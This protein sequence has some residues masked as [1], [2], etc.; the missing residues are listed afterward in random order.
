LFFVSALSFAA[1]IRP[2]MIYDTNVIMDNSWNE[3]IHNGIVRFEQKMK[4][5][6]EEVNIVD[7]PSFTE[8]VSKYVEEGYGP[9]MLNNVDSGKDVILKEILYAYPQTRFIVFNGIFNIPNAFYFMFS[10]QESSFLAG[11]LA[12]KKTK[13]NRLGFVGGM[14]IATIR[15]FLCGYISGARYY[16][17]DIKVDWDFIGKDFLAWDRPEDAYQLALKQI[18]KGADIIFTPSG[19]SS[20]GALRATHERGVLGIGVDSNQNHLFPG[21]VLTSALVKVDNAV[22]RALLAAQRNIWGDQIKTMGLQ[23]NG[24]GLAYDK[25]NAPLISE[26][27]RNEVEA[28]K[29]KII[30][31]EIKINNYVHDKQCNINGEVLF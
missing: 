23:E 25:Y 17:P 11:Y 30:L 20:I 14:D 27:L 26:K 22:F 29:E 21:S 7:V 1:N 12:S 13:T 2:V 15:S 19:G 31:K 9:I 8:K 28:V 5:D 10:Y 3:V 18:D 24:V 6:V 16:N 4:I